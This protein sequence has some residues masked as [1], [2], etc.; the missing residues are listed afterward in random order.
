VPSEL[1][2]QGEDDSTTDT[3]RGLY[4]RTVK[5]FADQAYRT[6]LITYKEMSMSEYESIK[7][8]ANNFDKESDKEVLETDLTAV[9]IFGL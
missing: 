8:N 9:G 4:E 6:L 1:L 7:A 5:K 2:N 3:Y